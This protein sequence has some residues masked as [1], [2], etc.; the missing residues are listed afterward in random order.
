MS[1]ATWAQFIVLVVAFAAVAPLL[2]RYMARVYGDGERAP[3]D[4][5]F[6]PVE[7]A[8]Y[9]LCGVDERREQR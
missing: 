3:G 9:R 7:R 2:G 6:L 8:I 4:R 5:L 1:A